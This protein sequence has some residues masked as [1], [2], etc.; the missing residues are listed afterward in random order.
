VAYWLLQYSPRV[1]DLEQ[2]LQ[3][4]PIESWTVVRYLDE[5]RA[6]DQFALW[7]AGPPSRRGV[8]AFGRITGRPVEGEPRPGP[9]PH[10]IDQEKAARHRHWLPIQLTRVLQQP[11]LA[12]DLVADPRFA[13]ATILREFRSGNPFRLTDE[14]WAAITEQLP[15]RAAGRNPPW[16]R[17]EIIL[18]LDLYLRRRPSIPGAD[19]PEVV[20][21]S[22]FLN[23]L[24]IHTVRPD[25]ERFRNPNGVALKLANFTAIAHPGRGMAAGS[26]LDRAVWEELAGDPAE[27]ARLAAAIRAAA[28][29]D[30]LPPV[31]E[32]DEEEVETEEGRLLY[33]RHRIRERDPR[34]VKQRK[35]QAKAAG[36][37]HCEVCAFNFAE[38]YGSRGGDFIEAH[39]IVPV[40]E[41][42]IRKVRPGD[43]ALVC[44]NCHSMLH[45]RP[46]CTPANLRTTLRK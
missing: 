3:D 24:P 13:N 30:E 46:W 15:T 29:A 1:F 36:K 45:R 31:P 44:S 32:P 12:V 42:G 43:L 38:I 7:R 5:P 20:E 9:Q 2:A 16:A 41:G 19:D 8:E 26:R 6:G 18:A 14:Q 37:L 34:I 27:V 21:L 35:A 25:L 11:V 4:G 22:T 39:Q 17:D 23:R 10:W 33:R 40:S 28:T